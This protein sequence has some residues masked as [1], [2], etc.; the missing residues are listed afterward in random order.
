[1][2]GYRSWN[3]GRSSF[4][5]SPSRPRPQRRPPPARAPPAR[6]LPPRAGPRERREKGRA[7]GCRAREPSARKAGAHQTAHDRRVLS[8]RSPHESAPLILDHR[9]DR[10]LVE[11]EGVD[12]EPALLGHDT[13]VLELG[14]EREGGV[15]R[16]T[17]P[18]RSVKL[19]VPPR[20]HRPERPNGQLRR[21]RQRARSRR[22]RYRAVVAHVA[23]AGAARRVT[24][25]TYAAPV[26]VQRDVRGTVARREAP[27]VGTVARTGT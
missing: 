21:E 12:V 15:E 23:R 10:A 22:R 27:H 4:T 9:E 14:C 7:S 18:I 1:M 16:V 5:T 8:H 17:E 24:E 19:A 6:R 3:A 20:D 2:P 25:E 26:H 11:P 13:A